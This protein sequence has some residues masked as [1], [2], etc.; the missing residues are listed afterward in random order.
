MT[1]GPAPT[2][3]CGLPPGPP[4]GPSGR[5]PPA[6]RPAPPTT[7]GRPPPPSTAGRPTPPRVSNNAGGPALVEMS[8]AD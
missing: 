3:G 2:R 1:A 4:A 8:L 7:A 6:G 5:G